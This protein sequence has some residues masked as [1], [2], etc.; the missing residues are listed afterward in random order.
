MEME[1]SVIVVST[2]SLMQISEEVDGQIDRVRDAFDA[3]GK[4]VEQTSSYWEGRGQ[5][6][7]YAQYRSKTDKI[8]TALA[9]FQEQTQDLRT[10]AGI[11]V[12]TETKLTEES[13]RL[14][15]NVI[16]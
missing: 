12:E 5:D 3:I 15:D 9:R 7:F 13:G 2:E 16:I 8:R 14:S 6:S 1:N 10:M 11:Y 4:K